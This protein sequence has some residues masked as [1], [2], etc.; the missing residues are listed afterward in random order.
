MVQLPMDVIDI[1]LQYCPFSTTLTAFP[2]RAK[3]ISK[4]KPMTMEWAVQD[5]LLTLKWF[6]APDGRPLDAIRRNDVDI[7]LLAVKHNKL[8]V[9]KWLAKHSTYNIFY[10]IN[11]PPSDPRIIDWWINERKLAFD[12]TFWFWG[13]LDEGNIRG[14]ELVYMWCKERP[15]VY[16]FFI[17]ECFPIAVETA[18]TKECHEWFSKHHLITAGGSGACNHT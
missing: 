3:I 15:K 5:G 18:P 16:K 6:L 9:L 7:L 2:E 8:S 13:F 14:M 12:S 17:E 11:Y 4:H 1:I 10:D